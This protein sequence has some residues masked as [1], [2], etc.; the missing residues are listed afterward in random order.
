MFIKLFFN[1]K[2]LPHS[3]LNLAGVIPLELDPE[4]LLNHLDLS[5]YHPYSE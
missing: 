1:F 3:D 2:F 4:K 5:T